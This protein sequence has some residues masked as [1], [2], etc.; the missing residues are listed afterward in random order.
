MKA[1]GKC[2]SSEVCRIAQDSDRLARLRDR[3]GAQVDSWLRH[4]IEEYLSLDVCL[5]DLFG[6]DHGAA[7]DVDDRLRQHSQVLQMTL[8]RHR[9]AQDM[10]DGLEPAIA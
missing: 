10:V 9:L 6:V 3:M 5:A 8:E 4:R 1:C 7:A 2:G